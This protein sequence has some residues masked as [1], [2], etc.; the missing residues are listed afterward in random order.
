MVCN[1]PINFRQLE[2]FRSVAES[3]SFTRASHALFIS[4]STVSQH[5]RELEDSLK[6]QLFSRNRR[7]VSLTPAGDTLLEYGRSIFQMLE[8][9]ETAVQTTPDGIPFNVGL[10]EGPDGKTIIAAVN[11]GSYVG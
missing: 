8:E 4:Q 9:A 10:W 2:V 7:T 3:M 5:I 11:P 6:V 1:M